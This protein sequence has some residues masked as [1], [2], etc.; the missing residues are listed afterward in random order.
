MHRELWYFLIFMWRF[1]L[2]ELILNFR[3]F[4]ELFC[5]F[6]EFGANLCCCCFISCV[7]R[8]ILD[9]AGLIRVTI[10]RSFWNCFG[11]WNAFGL[12]LIAIWKR[13]G[14]LRFTCPTFFYK[15]TMFSWLSYFEVIFDSTYNF[16]GWRRFLI[17]F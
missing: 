2:N 11:K 3:N 1:F 12:G 13:V 5:S 9:M 4:D 10:A 8:G 14:L 15:N 17:F 16:W 7:L 6:F